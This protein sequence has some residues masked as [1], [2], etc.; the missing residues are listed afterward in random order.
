M[1]CAADAP[2]CSERGIG[3]GEIGCCDGLICSSEN[4]CALETVSCGEQYD[5]CDYYEGDVLVECCPGFACVEGKGYYCEFVCNVEGASCASVDLAQEGGDS[6]CCEGL[7]C[8]D[9][10]VC[11]P[12]PPVETCSAQG[13]SC[14]ELECCDDLTCLDTVVC[15]YPPE[16]PEKPVTPA[17]SEVPVVKLPDTGAGQGVDGNEW[18]VP[19]VLGAAAAAIVGGKLLEKRG[20]SSTESV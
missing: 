13:A 6:G 8:N 16:V 4:Y 18:V 11:V 19:T 5:G 17:K 1:F 10:L 14:A 12:P 3:C 7:I 15:G 9:E 20:D 2:V